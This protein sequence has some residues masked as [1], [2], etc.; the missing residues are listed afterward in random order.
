[1]INLPALQQHYY[2]CH[3]EGGTTEESMRLEEISISQSCFRSN[4][5]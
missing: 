1:M 5:K 4:E 2:V 3:S